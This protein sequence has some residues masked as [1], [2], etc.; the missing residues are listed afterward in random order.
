M[1][2]F[3][4]T[5]LMLF[6]AGFPPL[7]IGTCLNSFTT[8]ANGHL[9]V[10]YTHPL[11]HSLSHSHCLIL[12]LGWADFDETEAENVVLSIG[13]IDKDSD[14]QRVSL[15]TWA[16]EYKM[17]PTDL[18]QYSAAQYDNSLF[19]CGKTEFHMTSAFL[20]SPNST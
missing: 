13:D 18:W 5:P 12:T 16:L 8:N 1:C 10:F 20:K 9:M 6:C 7:S 17:R 19:F 14:E 3:M 4:A 11:T 2:V 15:Q